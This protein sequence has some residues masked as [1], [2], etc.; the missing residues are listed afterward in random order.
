MVRS[1]PSYA[2]KAVSHIF[3]ASFTSLRIFASGSLSRCSICLY[4]RMYVAS[5]EQR[6]CQQKSWTYDPEDLSSHETRAG[7]ALLPSGIEW[8]VRATSDDQ[9]YP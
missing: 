3:H 7:L 8:R 9:V 6:L 1:L 2:G 5:V 4:A